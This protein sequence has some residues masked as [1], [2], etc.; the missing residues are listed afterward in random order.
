MRSERS[1]ICQAVVVSNEF[2]HDP[3]PGPEGSSG[4]PW[5]LIGLILVAIICG[6][7]VFQNSDRTQVDF[8]FFSFNSRVWVAI[9]VAMALG[10]VLD[11]F[12]IGWWRRARKRRDD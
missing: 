5:S 8:L 2:E 3:Q 7:F 6:I 1:S 12:I 9:A 10:V 11:R 4:P